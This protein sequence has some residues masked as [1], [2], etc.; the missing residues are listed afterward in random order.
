MRFSIL[1][2]ISGILLLSACGE[3]SGDPTFSFSRAV[4]PDARS[5][6][7]WNADTLFAYE[8]DFAVHLEL[9]AGDGRACVFGKRNGFQSEGYIS[10]WGVEW[11][12]VPS[13]QLDIRQKLRVIH[14]RMY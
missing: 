3:E 13:I 4:T 14:L 12:A 1:I 9:A 8:P 5:N 10:C 2:L 7:E 11:M 6:D